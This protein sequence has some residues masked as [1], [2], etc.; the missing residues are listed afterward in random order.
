MAAN[1]LRSRVTR[2]ERTASEDDFLVVLIR[3]FTVDRPPFARIGGNDGE[4]IS[5]QASESLEEFE[6]L[7][8]AAAK[9]AGDR[10][11]AIEVY[12]PWENAA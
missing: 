3:D 7:A 8:I 9:N 10:W 11:V 5:Q 4:Q 2:L 6:A 12:E 1:N